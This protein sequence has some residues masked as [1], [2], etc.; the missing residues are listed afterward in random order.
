MT[1]IASPT[2]TACGG[3]GWIRKGAD[4]RAPVA[5]C[6]C[7][8]EA[9]VQ[10]KLE[11]ANIP[12]RY[13]GST[14]DNFVTQAKGMDPSLDEAKLRCERYVEG[15]ARADYG[16]LF[17]GPPGV[18]KTHLAVAVLKAL[19][20]QHG[21]DGRFA[22]YRD[23]LRS[24]QDSYNPV[25]Q[26]SELEILRPVLE[27]DVVL[28]DELGSRRPSDWVLNT[29]TYILNTRYSHQRITLITTNYTDTAPDDT[30]MSLIERVGPY[31][32]SRLHEMCQVVRLEGDD[33]RQSTRQAAWR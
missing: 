29:V 11:A 19:I 32:R 33:F 1:E 18:G 4:P 17:C 9:E 25:S 5:R 31:A 22:D 13:G 10:R 20:D 7:F 27:A 21:I 14:L 3:T 26:A 16:L 15:F 23:L 8:R 24:I 30:Q 6:G 2:C 28:L 12:P